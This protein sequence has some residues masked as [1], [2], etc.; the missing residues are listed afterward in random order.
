MSL[1]VQ[2]LAVSFGGVEAVAGVSFDLA[3]GQCV[4]LVG[5]SGSGKSVTARA[6]LGLAGADA[7]VSAA[8]LELDG[9]PLPAAGAPAWRR[10]RGARIGL[11]LQ[12]ALGALDPLRPVGREIGDGL[13]LHARASGSERA[14][15][16]HDALLRA[17]IENPVLRARQRSG[18]LSGGLRQRALI[19]AAIALDPPYLVADEP[20]TA[21][22][23]GI[24]RQV[25][26]ELG[27]LKAAGTGILLISHDLDAVAGLAD[28]VLVLAG[29]RVVESGPTTQ[30]LAAPE[31]PETRA[32]LAANPAGR[33]RG[34]RLSIEDRPPRHGRATRE[35]PIEPARGVGG[36]PVLEL[37]DVGVVHRTPDGPFSA[38]D[39]ASLELRRGETLGVV[40][41]S[42]SGKTTL[43]R[44]A[45]G[46]DAPTSGQVR[47][48][49][50][51]GGSG[52]GALRAARGRIGLVG[53]DAGGGFDPRW[54][55]ERTL[56]DA[57]A[58]EPGG[59]RRTRTARRR[60]VAAL[61]DAV[62]LSGSLAGRAPAS[63]SGGQRQ[64]V[65][66]ARALA[67]GP[68]LL[69]LDEPVS[70]LDLTVQARVL[71]L[72]DDLQ[73]ER[74]LGY[75]LISHD[76]DVVAHASD[77]IAVVEA[78][79]IVEQGDA[80]R[81]LAAPEHPATRRLLG[82]RRPLGGAARA[83]TDPVS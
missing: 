69:V 57:L 17:G 40:G 63:L 34:T 24:G 32:L 28:H 68:E 15:R 16:V 72:L 18:E 5:E 64:R 47:R 3:A 42:G 35:P 50:K 12:D 62:G 82:A 9:A 41:A 1:R 6:L 7:R 4:A 27:R 14:G 20:T 67:A 53:Q 46:L 2:D 51:P 81:V 80:A 8:A 71:D 54:S 55:V 36:P 43:A 79:R 44:V 31:A 13:R 52:P 65:A 25:L 33:P 37:R 26:A 77:R 11:V 70:A 75:L 19:A 49:G 48:F 59:R 30:L 38:L 22:D 61:L 66:I 21:L 10:I 74:G 39:G 56:A 58:A 78:G 60:A 23:A 73:R 83:Q 45:I 76:L 29:G